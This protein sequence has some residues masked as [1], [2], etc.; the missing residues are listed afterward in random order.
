M[1]KDELRKLIDDTISEWREWETSATAIAN[2][3]DDVGGALDAEDEEGAVQDALSNLRLLDWSSPKAMTELVED[4]TAIE[5][6]LDEL[7]EELSDGAE[8]EGTPQRIIDDDLTDDERRALM[9][10]CAW[11]ELLATEVLLDRHPDGHVIATGR[12]DSKFD[13]TVFRNLTELGS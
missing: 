1:D 2:V 6:G 9:G 11:R 13:L 7:K 10:Y 5:N 8:V 4:M 12:D 3:L